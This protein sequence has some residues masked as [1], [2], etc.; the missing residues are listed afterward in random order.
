VFGSAALDE[1]HEEGERLATRAHRAWD[2]I[3]T[4]PPW[5]VCDADQPLALDESKSADSNELEGTHSW[6][7]GR[8]GDSSRVVQRIC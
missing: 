1:L 4:S 5:S 7:H 2:E 3:Q 8:A 6:T